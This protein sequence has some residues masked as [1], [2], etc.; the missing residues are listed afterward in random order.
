MPLL[1]GFINQSFHIFINQSL[2]ISESPFS[3]MSGSAVFDSFQM[4]RTVEKN[5]YS[6]KHPERYEVVCSTYCSHVQLIFFQP[7]S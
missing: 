4:Y 6:S 7:K 3:E 2:G 1:I 5:R